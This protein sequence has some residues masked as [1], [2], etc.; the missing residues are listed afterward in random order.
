MLICE[1]A[2]T[3]KNV[4]WIQIRGSWKQEPKDGHRNDEHIQREA[5]KRKDKRGE[6]IHNEYDHVSNLLE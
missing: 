4:V 3:V 6:E 1:H 5:L 2:Q